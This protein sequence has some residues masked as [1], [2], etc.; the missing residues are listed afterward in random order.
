MVLVFLI[1]KPFISAI[2]SSFVLAYVFYPVYKFFKRFLKNS[3]L[4]AFVVSVIIVIFFTIPVVFVTNAISTEVETNHVFIKQIL[5]TENL[6]EEGCIEDNFLCKPVD[7][8]EK[9]L[10]DPEI[11]FHLIRI[12]N[13]ARNFLITKAGKFILSVPLFLFNF[14][15]M[16]FII[17]YLF[18]GGD[19]IIRRIRKLLPLKKVHRKN[20]MEQIS[21]VTYAVIYGHI[22]V[23][24]LQGTLGGIA[25]WIFGVTSPVLWGMA[26]FIFALIPFIGTVPIWGTATLFK[27]FSNHPLQALGIL[28]CGI[29]IS[30]FDN[31]L[32]PKIIAGRANVHPVLVLLGLI[33]GWLFFG[34]IGIII[35]PVILSIFVTFIEIYEEREV[36][37]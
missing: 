37:A 9:Y 5:I 28:L 20:I 23:A 27:A 21:D 16:V 7:W 35:G 18:K 36:E 17:F 26:M 25:F 19:Q 14:F 32:K 2:L 15:I 12:A 1:L 11:K 29:F 6:F 34:F 10:K 3:S 8:V 13:D 22:V 4:S 24:A 33:G 30:T 31:F